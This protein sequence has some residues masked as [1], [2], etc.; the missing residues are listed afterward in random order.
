MF[1]HS[2]DIYGN[3]LLLK[4]QGNHSLSYKA[5]FLLDSLVLRDLK[6]LSSFCG[7]GSWGSEQQYRCCCWEH[8][9]IPLA[10]P[11]SVTWFTSVHTCECICSTLCPPEL[12]LLAGQV[13]ESGELASPGRR[14]QPVREGVNGWYLVIAFTHQNKSP[15]IAC[16]HWSST[17]IQLIGSV[18]LSGNELEIV[19]FFVCLPVVES[20]HFYLYFL[21]SPLSP[22]SQSASGGTQTMTGSGVQTSAFFSPPLV[23]L[24]EALSLPSSFQFTADKPAFPWGRTALGELTSFSLGFPVWPPGKE[25]YSP[26][27]RPAGPRTQRTDLILVRF[28]LNLIF[29]CVGLS[30][31]GKIKNVI[32]DFPGDPGVKALPSGVGGAGLMPGQWSWD[33]AGFTAPKNK[34]SKQYCNKFKDVFKNGPL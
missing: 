3:N 20:L 15:W 34:T 1:N 9:H 27:I 18:P 24:P 12:S 29:L 8:A 5:A 4:C 22:A 14:P 7:Y 6:G 33:P 21:P 13:E 28:C 30:W 2:A 17:R 31:P 26:E 16:S 11:L 25:V 32:R 23:L 10:F 19:S